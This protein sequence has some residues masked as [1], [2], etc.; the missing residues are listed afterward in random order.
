MAVERRGVVSA[1]VCAGASERG[2]GAVVLSGRV[3]NLALK[4]ADRSVGGSFGD[5]AWTG[6]EQTLGRERRGHK[7]ATP[8]SRCA[9]AGLRGCAHR[10]RRMYGGTDDTRCNG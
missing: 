4:E 9:A 7:Q 3:W 5:C 1:V 8:R 6:I 10:W 2:V